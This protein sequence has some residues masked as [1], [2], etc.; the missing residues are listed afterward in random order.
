L[1]K[2]IEKYKFSSELAKEAII[3]KIRWKKHCH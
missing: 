3:N 1:T 2:S